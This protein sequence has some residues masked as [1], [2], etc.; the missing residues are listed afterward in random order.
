MNCVCIQLFVY[1]GMVD[2]R[3]IML[4]EVGWYGVGSRTQGKDHESKTKVDWGVKFLNIMWFLVASC[5][6]YN[7]LRAF[8]YHVF[9]S[10]QQTQVT[11]LPLHM[12][13]SLIRVHRYKRAANALL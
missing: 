1:S 12:I 10:A 4:V 8:A 9:L 13:A 2:S 7:V 6:S 5:R 11:L 3:I